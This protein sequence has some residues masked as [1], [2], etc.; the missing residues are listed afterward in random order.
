[1]NR[2]DLLQSSWELSTLYLI[3]DACD[4]FEVAWRTGN[5]P[6]I[7]EYLAR[8]P[9]PDRNILLGE[10]LAV[11]VELRRGAGEDPTAEDY[12]RRF[13][14]HAD[15]I[16]VAL[17][18]CSTDW[19]EA[20]STSLSMSDGP[21]P[22][23]HERQ[24]EVPGRTGIVA[25]EE[26]RPR[27]PY[28]GESTT[29]SLRDLERLIAGRT[30]ELMPKTPESSTLTAT[31]LTDTP[32]EVTAEM[33]GSQ[34]LFPAQ[35][36]TSALI[37]DTL[38]QAISTEDLERT[39]PDLHDP[40]SSDPEAT[41][42]SVDSRQSPAG[43]RVGSAPFA[44]TRIPGYGPLEKLGEGGMGV[45][46]KA[47]HVGLNRLVAVKMIRGGSRERPDQFIRF[48]IEAETIAQLRH[49]HIL[50][51]YDIGTANDRPFLALELLD[52]GSLADRI[53]STPQPGRA[54]A[55][56]MVTL[57][58]AMHAAHQA[59]IIHRDLKPTNILFT[60]NG[61]PKISDFGLAKR[62]E[63][64]TTPTESGVI[65][66]S[67]SYMAPEQ[68]RGRARQVGP[69]TDVYSLGAILYEMLTGRPPFKGE[70]PV[71]TVR[72]VTDD[73]PV[74][75]TRLVPRLERD[76]ETICMKC[77]SKEPLKRYASASELADDLERYLNGEAIKARSTRYWEH[78]VKWARRRPAMAMLVA[79]SLLASLTLGA[80]GWWLVRRENLRVDQLRSEVVP[81][82][83]IGQALL[84]KEKW[85]DAK[86]HLIK[87][88]TQSLDEPQLV[89]LRRQ[90]E[91]LLEQAEQRPNRAGGS[92]RRAG[93]LGL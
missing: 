49:P 9:R 38:F 64:Q 16:D 63:S 5:S 47:R 23:H 12:R 79:L 73:D 3:D 19:S 84:A 93:G 32:G 72:Q 45:V 62:M 48:R 91:A 26:I 46:Y 90:A 67:P 1:M 76:L 74:P 68:A 44:G 70:T 22:P 82:L 43:I 50:Q 41:L 59:G 51:I 6:R 39:E 75:P 55:E 21:R 37:P 53:A 11:E 86:E 61:I 14:K 24:Y 15:A 20:I 33:P 8:W 35:G 69:A 66:G 17:R 83:L 34:E 65:M 60:S 92:R 2:D 7:E 71:E 58:R 54:A 81:S 4:R 30:T 13:P 10:L 78:G 18:E 29:E 52:G 36:A 27:G 31:D 57:A 89:E 40:D 88:H 85:S 87:A 56:L 77:L 25:S 28:F 80:T 42:D